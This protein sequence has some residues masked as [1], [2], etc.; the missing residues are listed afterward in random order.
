MLDEGAE[1]FAV[2]TGEVVVRGQVLVAVEPHV[3]D[4]E[5]ERRVVEQL[6]DPFDVVGVD[7]RDHDQVQV[8]LGRSQAGQP[9]VQ[10]RV[11]GNGAA[12]DQDPVPSGGW[13]PGEEEAVSLPRGQRLERQCV[14][15]V[16]RHGSPPM[17][18]AVVR[19]GAG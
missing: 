19:E 17:S 13:P 3:T 6:D 10:G 5:A 15:G 16:G 1:V 12:V 8:A 2:R 4:C 9:L 18:T 11:G 14:R 7:V